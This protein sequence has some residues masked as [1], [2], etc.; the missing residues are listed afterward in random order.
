M[1]VRTYAPD[2]VSVIVGAFPIGGFAD[3][4]FITVR[5]SVDAFRKEV[6]VEGVVTRVR[7]TDK[8]GEIQLTLSQTSLSNDALSSLAIADELANVGVVP[9]FIKDNSKGIVGSR[10]TYVSAF[11]WVRK[12]PDSEFSKSAANREWMI[13]VA[14]LILFVGGI[15]AE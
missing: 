11:G 15:N 2:K 10:S 4:S 9:I 1:A 3:G 6:G 14:E 7:N 12:I 13:D 5:R 8:S